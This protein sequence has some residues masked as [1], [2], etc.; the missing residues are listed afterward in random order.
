MGFAWVF[1]LAAAARLE[2]AAEEEAV[3]GILVVG[4]F[5]DAPIK[6]NFFISHMSL[7]YRIFPDI[8]T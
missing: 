4:T 3:P 8:F 7:C 1:T 6:I 5:S 2:A